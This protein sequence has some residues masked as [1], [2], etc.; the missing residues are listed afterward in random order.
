MPLVRLESFPVVRYPFGGYWAADPR[1]RG[2]VSI[3]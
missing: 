1:Q 2:K 3:S